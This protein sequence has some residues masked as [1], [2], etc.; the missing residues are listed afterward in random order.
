MSLRINSRAAN[1]TAENT[2]GKLDRCQWM[3]EADADGDLYGENGDTMP[4]YPARPRQPTPYE[5]AWDRNA[6][7]FSRAG[8]RDA[9]MR[10]RRLRRKGVTLGPAV[11]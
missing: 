11:G 1:F 3:P 9:S 2:H 6:W 7:R 10:P 4:Y 8:A 5:L